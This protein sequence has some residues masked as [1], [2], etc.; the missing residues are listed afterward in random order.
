MS[1]FKVL[2]AGKERKSKSTNWKGGENINFKGYV[3]IYCPEHPNHNAHGYIL[4]HRFVMEKYLGRFLKKVEVVHHIDH[5]K[6]N[7]KISNLKL[8]SSDVEHLQSESHKYSEFL[9][10]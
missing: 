8:Y 4:K 10:F 1:K 6:Q 7:N 9:Y 2:L 5:N 3:L